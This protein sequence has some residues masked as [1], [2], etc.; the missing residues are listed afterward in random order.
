MAKFMCKV[1]GASG[2]Q[3]Q[4]TEEA[5]TKAE[6]LNR[7]HEKNIY[8]IEMNEVVVRKKL[9]RHVLTMKELMTFCKQMGAML[10]AGISI[11]AALDTL[12]TSVNNKK[13]REVVLQLY[14][15]ILSGQSVS[16]SM[17]EMEDCFP[18]MLIYMVEVGENS[19]NLDKI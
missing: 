10:N 1:I 16:Q 4:Y 3:V 17:S 15:R 18:D 7:F 6:L 8:C 11:S 2:K 14:E 19:G 5:S 13:L 12:Y 9:I